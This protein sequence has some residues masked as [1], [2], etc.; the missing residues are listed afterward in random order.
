[1]RLQ[2]RGALA[3]LLAAGALVA[4]GKKGPPLAPE[5]RIP[6]APADLHGAV[7][8]QTIVVSWTAT[9]RRMDNSRLRT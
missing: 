4:C 6:A 9:N 2:P 1:M 3:L 8:Q 5:L 7:D